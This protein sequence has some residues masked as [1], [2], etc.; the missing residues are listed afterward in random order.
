MRTRIMMLNSRSLMLLLWG[1]MGMATLWGQ[2]TSDKQLWQMYN[3][4]VLDAIVAD[5]SEIVH[6]LIPVTPDNKYLQWQTSLQGNWVLT[7]V[8]TR[9]GSGFPVGDT[10]VNSW[11]PVWVTM[12]PQLKQW[13]STNFTGKGD[14][15]LRAEQLLGLPPH[16]GDSTIVE[17]WVRAE[18]LYRPAYDNSITTTSSGIYM[19]DTN[20]AYINW[21]NGNIIYSYF[22]QKGQKWY[23]W[24]RLGYTYDWGN[25][26]K[27]VGLSEFVLKPNSRMIVKTNVPLPKYIQGK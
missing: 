27:H 21:F 18:D 1:I 12:A 4:G 5:S 25:P 8:F 14:C 7:C 17:L 24:T 10:V 9:Y 3:A 13:F 15:Y 23:P 11:G 16:T 22:P 26:K 20:K 2:K 19:T 6:T